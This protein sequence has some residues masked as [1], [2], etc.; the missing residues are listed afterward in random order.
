MKERI[1]YWDVIKC[2]AIILVVWGHCLQYFSSNQDVVYRENLTFDFIYSF[3]MP[4]FMMVS[5]YFALSVF[6]SGIIETVL[7]KGRQL[8]LPSVST[9]FFV[10]LILI[11]VRQQQFLD[12]LKN[13]LWYCWSSYWFLKALFIFYVVTT[14]FVIV[15]QKS[16]MSVIFLVILG[17]AI[18]PTEWFDFVHCISMY[19]Y[20]VLGI[21]FHKY[22]RWLFNH[23]KIIGCT[24]LVIYLIMFFNWRISE[25]DMYVYLFDWD[26]SILNIYVTRVL[27]G[28]SGSIS[29]ILIIR[30]LCM[31]CHQNRVINSMAK[32][33]T[34]TLGIYVF[35]RMIVLYGNRIAP[36]AL[37]NLSSCIDISFVGFLY[38]YMICLGAT[39]FITY[40]CIVLMNMIRKNSC[41]KYILLGEK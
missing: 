12:S 28:T 2:I 15:W 3:H 24:A 23:T 37:E 38:D 16:K 30:K 7:K 34:N 6:R 13:L 20:F 27:I 33:G 9:Y 11:F 17:G 29:F 40:I 4:L 18:I 32:I 5:G 14:I 39:F 1:L 31:M 22:E 36:K 25:Y 41:L 19:P 21:L 10:G 26:W 8:Y 35:S